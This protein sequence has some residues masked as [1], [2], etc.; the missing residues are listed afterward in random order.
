MDFSVVRSTTVLRGPVIAVDDLVVEAPGGEL[1]GRQV[2]RHPGAVSV[3]AI[4]SDDNVVMVRQ[5]RAALDAALLEIPAGKRDVEGEAPEVTAGRELAEEVGLVA[6]SLMR[7]AEFHNS[8]GFCDEHSIVY[9]ATDLSPA[10]VNRQGAEEEHLEV[11]RVPLAEVEA[12]IAAGELRDAK[13]IIGV[14][15]ARGHLTR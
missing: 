9:L 1:L 15:L 10:P 11:V 6:G 12:L 8:P 2:V 4:D 5:Y 13:S 3:V 7:L 14:V